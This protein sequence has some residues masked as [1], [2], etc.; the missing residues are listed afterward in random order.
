MEPSARLA[1]GGGSTTS[2]L[3]FGTSD[4]RSGSEGKIGNG[5][6][7]A[8]ELSAGPESLESGPQ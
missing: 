3:N 6:E 7:A 2:E 5:A 4:S 1:Y 8:P